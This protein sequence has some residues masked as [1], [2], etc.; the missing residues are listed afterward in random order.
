M[1]P[2][3]LTS[4]LAQSG[5]SAPIEAVRSVGGGL[6][7]ESYIL[8]GED[9]RYVLRIAPP[10]ERPMLFYEVEMMR[11]E[12]GIHGLVR[13]HTDVPAPAVVHHD[14]SRR[15]IDRDFLVME[16]L[17]GCAGPFEHEELGRYVRQLHGIRGEQFGYPER[18]APTGNSWADLF[19][20][21]VR[22]IFDDCLRAGA[23]DREEHSRFLDIYDERWDAMTDEV[24]PRFLH[25]DLWSANILT[26]NGLITGIL[27]FDRGMYGDPELE[28]AVLD[29]Y[30]NSTPEFFAGYGRE[31]PRGPAAR[32][33]RNLYIVYEIIKYAFIRLARGGNRSLAR[34]F[35]RRCFRILDANPP[36]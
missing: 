2:S 4:L 8:E 26:R 32:T 16:F 3:Q 24:E 20:T 11:S 17:P 25:L 13:R 29:T 6:Y 12:P 18:E 31:R 22:L 35:V 15:H 19:R 7:N 9:G 33:R 23:I 14:F 5:F 10:D 27:D 34:S 28:F 1:Q 36:I 30:G 21:Y